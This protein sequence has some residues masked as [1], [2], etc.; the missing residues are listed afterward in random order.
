MNEEKIIN[1]CLKNIVV[2]LRKSSNMLIKT[3]SKD[4]YSGDYLK[5]G[6]IFDPIN[7]KKECEFWLNRFRVSVKI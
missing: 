2:M 4:K 3:F 5:E 7:E 6:I 1:L